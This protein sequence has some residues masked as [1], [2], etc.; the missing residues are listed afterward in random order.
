MMTPRTEE[1]G[2]PT[3]AGPN[4]FAFADDALFASL[5]EGAGLTDVTVDAVKFGLD[6]A[7]GDELWDGFGRGRASSAESVRAFKD[8]THPPLSRP[9]G[10]HEP[11]WS[12][13]HARCA[14]PRLPGGCE[15]S[16][17]AARRLRVPLA[18]H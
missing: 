15:G 16:C 13:P 14:P 10:T 5:L 4:F 12:A 6:L 18:S 1:Q 17:R 11:R 8:E 3:A 9:P 2:I 7:D